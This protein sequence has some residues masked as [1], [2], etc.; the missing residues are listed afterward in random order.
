MERVTRLADGLYQI[1][2]LMFDDTERL[3]CYLFDG[4]ERVLIEVGPSV[5]LHHLTDTLD[6][7]G[8]DDLSTIAVT[9]IHLDHAG[10]AGHLAA[11]YPN[12]RIGVHAAGAR[13]LANPQ[14]LWDSA[15]RIYGE[16]GMATM[17][18]PMEPIADDRMLILEEGTR[19]PL[20]AGRFLDVMDTPGHAKHHVV[21][22]D[23][24]SGGMFIGD[25]VGIAFPHGHFVQPVTPPPDLD[26]P[27]LVSQLRRMADR[28]PAFLGFA[29]FGRHDDPQAALAEAEA[30]VE[31]WVDFVRDLGDDT[32]AAAVRLRE[33]VLEGYRAQG[34]SED[35]I[36]TYDKNTFWPMMPAGIVRWLGLQS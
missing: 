23:P 17:W 29:H 19:I 5:T 10:G 26:P 35:V 4:P 28:D 21:F 36:A 34:V 27:L 31:A 8:I 16:E 33:W 13:H 32:E 25:S 20:G 14:R 1:D 11:R 9:H 22:L 15:T 2:A 12:A 3:A 18:G 6:S 24:E 30:R 7:L